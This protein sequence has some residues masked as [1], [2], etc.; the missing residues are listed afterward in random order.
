VTV[1]ERV[2][3]DL[4]DVIAVEL[5]CQHCHTTFSVPVKEWKPGEA[6]CSNCSEDLWG[7]QAGGEVQDLRNFASAL[8]ALLHR[9]KSLPIR[10][11]ISRPALTSGASASSATPTSARQ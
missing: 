11:R 2:V 7:Q 9:G 8:K 6:K 1:D 5:E 4:S 3:I 10:L